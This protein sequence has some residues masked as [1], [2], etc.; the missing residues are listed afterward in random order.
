MKRQ[1]RLNKMT[2]LQGADPESKA[3]S[4]KH[5]E[6]FRKKAQ[7]YVLGDCANQLIPL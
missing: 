7:N 2:D 5:I 3:S 1:R 6:Y 4:S